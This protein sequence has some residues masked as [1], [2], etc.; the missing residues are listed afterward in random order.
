MK[1]YIVIVAESVMLLI[2]VCVP[3]ATFFRIQHFTDWS[4]SKISTVDSMIRIFTNYRIS[5]T[6]NR[7]C[8]GSVIIANKNGG[9]RYV[10]VALE[11]KKFEINTNKWFNCDNCF[12]LI[13]NRRKWELQKKLQNKSGFLLLS[14]CTPSKYIHIYAYFSFFL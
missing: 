12:I 5:Y 1:R 4:Y 9:Y 2:F 13:Q 3:N 11:R 10:M 8:F 14:L 7:L 6:F